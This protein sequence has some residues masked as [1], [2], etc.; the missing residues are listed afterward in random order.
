[1]QTNGSSLTG[2][3]NRQLLARG[4]QT[5]QPH[6]TSRLSQLLATGEQENEGIIE[7]IEVKRRKTG[8]FRNGFEKENQLVSNCL[9]FVEGLRL[10]P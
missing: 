10:F 8:S 7:E 1:M 3:Y 6:M 9:L 2:G 5:Y 4:E